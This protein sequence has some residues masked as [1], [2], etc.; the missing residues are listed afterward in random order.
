MTVRGA[1]PRTPFAAAR[2]LE[3]REWKTVRAFADRL[4]RAGWKPP[5]A[6]RLRFVLDFGYATGLRARE[7]VAATLGDIEVETRG[8]W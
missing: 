1:H 7:F 4:E 8:T 2:A 3:G 6:H 5:A